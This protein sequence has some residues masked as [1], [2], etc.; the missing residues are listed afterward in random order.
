METSFSR[1]AAEVGAVFFKDARTEFRTRAAVN[2]IL[3]FALTTL[4]VV[5]LSLTTQGLVVGVR[6]APKPPPERVSLTLRALRAAHMVLVLATGSA[7]AEAVR[8]A[9]AGTV[10]SGMIE[11]ARWLLDTEADGQPS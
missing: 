9:R 3:L 8:Q 11:Q 5:S 4:M 7:K 6:G 2:A 1:W 10:P